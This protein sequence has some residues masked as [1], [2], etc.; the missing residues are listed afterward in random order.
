MFAG[1]ARLVVRLRY[2]LL[3]AWLVLLGLA[4]SQ[5]P[6]LRFGKGV[7]LA[8]LETEK[9]GQSTDQFFNQEPQW[10]NQGGKEL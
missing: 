9:T 1:Y 3:L 2:L 6:K 7:G 8:I 10:Q 5:L 4:V